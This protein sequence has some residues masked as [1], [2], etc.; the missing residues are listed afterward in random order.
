MWFFKKFNKIDKP[1]EKL[2]KKNHK[3][4]TE[5]A[6]PPQTLK[7]YKRF[8][9]YEQVYTQMDNLGKKINFYIKGG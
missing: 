7:T 3:I 8:Q 1:L 5:T 6:K 2:T 4:M 9:K